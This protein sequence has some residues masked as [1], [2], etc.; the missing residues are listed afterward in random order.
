MK[1]L[2]IRAKITLWFSAALIIIMGLTFFV[3]LFIGNQIIQKTIRD[4]L[5]EAV[6]HN[7]DEVEYYRS[8]EE[9]KQISGADHFE[10]WGDGYL[11]IDDDFLDEVNDVYT[12][13][14]MSDGTLVYGENPIA[15]YT[16]ETAFADTEVQR[17]RIDG[18][19]YYIFDKRLIQDGLDGLWLRGIVSEAQGAVQMTGIVRT[20]LIL[21]PMIA[22]LAI[23]GGYLIAR[24]MLK[25]IQDISECASE[26]RQG[27]D[28]NKRIEIGSGS[29]ELHKLADNFNGMFERLNSSFQTERQ[30]T[31]DASHELRTP[32]SVIMAQCELTLE[33][34][35]SKE[36]YEEA[37]EVIQRQGRKMSKLINDM[38]DFTRLELKSDRYS[39]ENINFS[40]LVDSVCTD[41]AL[42]RE[43]GITLEHRED[44][45][46]MIRGNRGL[47]TRMLTNLISNAYRY[48][49]DNGH[50]Y[51]KL[52][53]DE[54][55]IS[56][57]VKDDGIGI[58][59]DEQEKIFRRFYQSDNSRT[60]EGT[61]LGL[62]MVAEIVKFHGGE[63][64]VESELGVG[65]TFVC[66]FK[67]I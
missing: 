49:K 41:T 60:G 7:V 24:R 34:E 13:L 5:I 12:S 37:L 29:D 33:K 14:C 3:V 6:E 30:F 59:K 38:L 62:S 65:S 50:I 26:I 58:D 1:R 10:Q 21:M 25:P 2:S 8:L 23:I 35:R 64:E 61:G 39:V 9:I 22:V 16:E 31:S 55:K 44:K 52:R 51:V 40:E 45:G 20:S 56:L 11:E 15:R 28:L 63:I 42:I 47:L 54:E 67:K 27:T 36:E 57:S 43:K 19:L 18:T 53:A 17:K 4:N 48:G 32:M 66:S 46:V